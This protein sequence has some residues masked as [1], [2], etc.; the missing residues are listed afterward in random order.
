VGFPEGPP[1][2][3][4]EFISSIN[5]FTKPL[6]LSPNARFLG[7]LPGGACFNIDTLNTPAYAFTIR[8]GQLNPKKWNMS[9]FPPLDST[10]VGNGSSSF[11]SGKYDGFGQTPFP[12]TGPEG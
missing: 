1:T 9:V 10:K 8:V 6:P 7:P 3:L 2:T 4:T 11:I 5:A 12:F